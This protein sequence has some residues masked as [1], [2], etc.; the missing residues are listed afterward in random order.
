LRLYLGI[1]LASLFFSFHSAETCI[2]KDYSNG[3]LSVSGLFWEGQPIK[4]NV[5]IAIKVEE[6]FH[7]QC[8]SFQM[9]G[10]KQSLT[11]TKLAI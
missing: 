8:I 11:K 9:S 4:K 2:C 6:R 1:E 5:K 7:F 3:F 10:C